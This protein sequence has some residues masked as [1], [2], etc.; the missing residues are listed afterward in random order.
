MLDM[1]KA[2]LIFKDHY[3]FDDGDIVEMTIWQVPSPVSPSEH[4]FKYSLFYG[5]KGE[6]I[7]GYDNER[8]KGDHKHVRGKESVFKFSSVDQ[9]VSDFLTDV[10]EQQ[11]D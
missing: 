4:P 11:H 7:V 3:T 5:H 10:K 8:G 1:P 6:R 9:L 2:K